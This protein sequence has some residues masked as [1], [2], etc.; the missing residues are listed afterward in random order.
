[1][2]DRQ[3][4]PASM[5]HS[6]FGRLSGSGVRMSFGKEGS[7]DDGGSTRLSQSHLGLSIM[8]TVQ[9]SGSSAMPVQRPRPPARSGRQ[10]LSK[11]HPKNPADSAE[12]ARSP[13]TSAIYLDFAATTPVDPE[14]VDVM[15]NF[16]GGDGVYANPSSDHLPGVAA[17]NAV[18]AA[19]AQVAILLGCSADEVIWTSGATEATNIA[20]QGVVRESS[21]LLPHIVTTAVEHS[22]TLETVKELERLG[23]E[24]TRVRPAECGEAI[25]SETII[26][27]LQAN[28]VVVSIIHVN[29]ETGDVFPDLSHLASHLR[30]RNVLLHVDAAQSASRVVLRDLS[31]WV[32]LMS[33][34]GHKIYGPKGVGVLRIA[35]HA[36]D[37][38]APV[39]FGGGQE[40]GIRPGTVATHQVAG[41]GTASALMSA[42]LSEDITHLESLTERF[43]RGLSSIEGATLNGTSLK[44]PGIFN[45]YLE[46]VSA[47]SLFIA[48]DGFAVSR[49]S[50]CSSAGVQPSH[51]L[52]GLGYAREQCFDSFRVS[53][54]RTTTCLEVDEFL[55]RLASVAPTLRELAA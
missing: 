48:L 19:R 42:R 27:A 13:A 50:A 23:A 12:M 30:E 26:D 24:V 32:D 35:P 31:E 2:R 14:V 7:Q 47:E 52:E 10:R 34:S 17:S 15:V 45:V 3:P 1:M 51:V 43:C 46:G 6:G 49:G 55:E 36:F 33:L 40:R 37:F 29:N 20:L 53:F 41:M 9:T 38:L 54:G 5:G 44:A 4:A 21:S 18:E 16:L 25:D 22:A 28:T 8:P 39:L 11:P